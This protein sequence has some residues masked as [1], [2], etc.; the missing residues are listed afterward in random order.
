MK[1]PFLWIIRGYQKVISP[2]LPPSCRYEPSCSQYGYEAIDKHGVIKGS[3]LAAW[4]VLRCN[5]WGKGG[6]D[7]VP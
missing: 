3:G 4:R 6:Y 5:P 1:Y 2:M 7:P